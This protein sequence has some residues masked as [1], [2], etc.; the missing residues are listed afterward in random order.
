MVHSYDGH[1]I[2]LNGAHEKLGMATIAG[3]LP[4]R[5]EIPI[6]AAPLLAH[7]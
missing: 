6:N 5:S 3:L 1:H 4:L 7:K 2:R